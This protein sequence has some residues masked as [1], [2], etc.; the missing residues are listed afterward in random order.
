LDELSKWRLAQAD[1]D[2]MVT[3][4]KAND[5]FSVVRIKF[6]DAS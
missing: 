3:A 2:N 6:C 4:D 1:A 5:G